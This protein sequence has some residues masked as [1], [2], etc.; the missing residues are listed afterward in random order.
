MS[1]IWARCR[2]GDN[3]P[4]MLGDDPDSLHRI[5]DEDEILGRSPTSS[6]LPTCMPVISI[7]PNFTLIGYREPCHRYLRGSICSA[8]LRWPAEKNQTAAR[9]F[10]RLLTENPAHAD[11]H[12]QLAEI[13]LR[14]DLAQDA[15]VHFR[16]ALALQPSNTDLEQ[17]IN[18]VKIKTGAN[19][20]ANVRHQ[21]SSR[22]AKT[23]VFI[24]RAFALARGEARNSLRALGWKVI[25]VFSSEAPFHPLKY[26]DDF[27]YYKTPWELCLT[28]ENST[29]VFT[30]SSATS[31]TT[32]QRL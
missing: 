22:D 17:R 4:F 13:L 26:F 10:R 21:P 27:R 20:T 16:Y 14:L 15:L 5:V 28:R 19:E 2:Y 3:G 25:L 18:E 24:S 23:V 12:Q 32:R 8:A 29:L 31:I 11:G 9:I 7:R 6:A 30:M 1:A